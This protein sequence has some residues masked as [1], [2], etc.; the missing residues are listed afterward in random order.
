LEDDTT[1]E[2][3]TDNRS[4]VC[5]SKESEQDYETLVDRAKLDPE[6]NEE[7]KEQVA[8]FKHYESKVHFCLV[9]LLIHII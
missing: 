2:E 7:L 1:D 6:A 8:A 3:S 4:N 9:R 5:Q